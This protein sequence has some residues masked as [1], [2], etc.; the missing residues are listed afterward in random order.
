MVVQ[1]RPSAWFL[2][3]SYPS[4]GTVLGEMRRKWWALMPHRQ[5]CCC[6]WQR[7]GEPLPRA[8]CSSA[9]PCWQGSAGLA[10]HLQIPWPVLGLALTV[11]LYPR[12]LI[13][14]G[15]ETTPLF[16]W[17]EGKKIGQWT[18]VQAGGV[19]GG[20]QNKGPD[21]RSLSHGPPK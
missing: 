4:G 2:P 15:W 10:W 9:R 11:L 6:T 13:P 1:R 19:F 8:L 18:H 20:F 16:P 5:R 3:N 17:F 7:H 12:P 21:P 14:G